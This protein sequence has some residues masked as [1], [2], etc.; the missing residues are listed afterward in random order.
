MLALILGAAGGLRLLQLGSLGFNSDEAVYAGQGA[1]I[2]QDPALKEFFP[3]FRSHPLLFQVVLGVIFRFG[4]HD[5]T[6]RLAAVATG[7]GTVYL[8]YRLGKL[9]Y[10]EKAGILAAAFLAVMPYHV[11]VTRQ[12]LLDGPM[13]LFSTLTL[14]LMARFAASQRPA[15]LYAAGA[16]MGLTFLAKETGIV[17]LGAVYAFLALSS[18]IRLRLRDL[19]LSTLT[20][21]LILAPYP[22]T[23]ALAGGGG[24]RTTQQ[25]LLWQLSRRPN[26]EW[27]FY[28]ATV[29]PA[30]GLL[31]VLAAA[32]GF[33]LLR[34][35]RSWREALLL[36][37]ITIPFLFFQSWPVKGFHYLLLVAPPIAIL[38]GR[39][40]GR[41]EPSPRWASGRGSAALPLAAAGLVLLTLLLPAWQRVHP[42]STG[43]FLAGS[44]GVPGGR[45]AG[46]WLRENSPEGATLMTIGP[47]MANILRFYGHREAFGL[48]VSPNPLHRNPA[49]QPI[50][51]PDFEIRTGEIQYLV[52]DAYS[53]GRSSFFSEK[54]LR[55]AERYNGRAVHTEAVEVTTP[56]GETTMKPVIIIYEV[57]P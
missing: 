48:S 18:S 14:Y 44:G 23:L 1:A 5:L 40:L 45:E 33:W 7:V 28:P 12:V 39:T 35:E 31:V 13:T 9:L 37:W 51:N 56:D 15:W 43:T 53:A 42:A 3:I 54:I 8:V 6:G 29:T 46:E 22:M 30:I 4:V 25:Y 55:Y 21:F 27:S 36:S 34:H 32:L 50:R 11:V 16:G 47:S 52:W 57:R 17:L 20:M 41:W 38:A 24:T 10:G 49:Y 26:H 19:A 2:A